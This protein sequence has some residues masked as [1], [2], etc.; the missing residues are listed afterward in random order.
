ML[1]EPIPQEE[2]RALARRLI[3][4][5]WEA[6]VAQKDQDAAYRALVCL[7]AAD[8]VG[9][10]QKLETEEIA[11]STQGTVDQGCGGSGSGPE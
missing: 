9:V 4:P 11:N 7:A 10:L 1:P 2:S 3:E 5:C 6:A 8:P